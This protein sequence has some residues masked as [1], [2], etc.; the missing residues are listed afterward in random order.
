[1]FMEEW[2]HILQGCGEECPVE[3]KKSIHFVKH[4]VHDEYDDLTDIA[5]FYSIRHVPLF[6]FFVVRFH[7]PTQS[8]TEL[9]NCKVVSY[10]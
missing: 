8:S 7:N 4:N 2:I 5:Q 3:H 10:I 9:I 1:M 6:S